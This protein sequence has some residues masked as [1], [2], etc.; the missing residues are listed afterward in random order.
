MSFTSPS[1]PLPP[2]LSL[3]LCALFIQL[4]S[5]TGYTGQAF[6]SNTS[7]AGTA[8]PSDA[9]ACPCRLQRLKVQWPSSSVEVEGLKTTT[10]ASSL[11]KLDPQMKTD[12]RHELLGKA[13]V[14]L[15]LFTTHFL[16]QLAQEAASQSIVREPEVLN[17]KFT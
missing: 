7:P 8:G 5:Y 13:R 11:Q 1:L 17:C 10:L 4:P 2:S 9:L 6:A 15:R 3:S 14:F 16:L 12:E